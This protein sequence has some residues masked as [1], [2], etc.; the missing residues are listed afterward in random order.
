M[1][2]CFPRLHFHSQYIL[3]RLHFQRLNPNLNYKDTTR[4]QLLQKLK[5]RVVQLFPS[6]CACYRFALLS[7]M[8][9]K[10][11]LRVFAIW[12]GYVVE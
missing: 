12:R 3:L 5:K 7:E 2:F 4:S 6:S 9:Q 1:Q 8:F 11:L 10:C